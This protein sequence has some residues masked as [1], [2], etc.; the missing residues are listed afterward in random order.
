M[1]SSSV[2]D[3]PQPIGFVG[4]G[5]MGEG[6]AARL[7]SQ[8]IAGTLK[9]PLLVWN[10]TP[11]KCHALCE[12]F[13]DK[14]IRVMETA[15]QVVQACGVTYSMLSTPEAARQVFFAEQV[16]VLA[17][18]SK[19]KCIV[20]CATLAERDMQ[21]MQQAVHDAG[22]QFLDAPVSGS[23]GPAA[24]GTLIF[25]CAG[26]AD[27]Y[28]RIEQNGLNAMGKASYYFG[29]SVGAG[30]RAKLVINSL[31]GTMAVAYGE[32]LALAQAVGLDPAQL[33]QIIG[34]GAIANPM[35]ALKGPKMI[36]GDHAPNFPLRH[37]TKDMTLAKNMAETAGVEYSV[38]NQAERIFT[39]ACEDDNLA[40]Q[41]FSAVFEK[42]CQESDNEVLKTLRKP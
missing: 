2:N 40:D 24:T 6:M 31:M 12:A 28:H 1:S 27:L 18:V 36:A 42:I 14:T 29:S 3:D 20:D 9:V 35:F 15:H 11:A 8:G 17:G 10:R 34:Q 37:A 38:M 26:D 5:I 7:L 19:G 13:P 16:G 22:G 41:D 33:I 30:T 23:K 21:S 39:E 25:L 32:G 4:L